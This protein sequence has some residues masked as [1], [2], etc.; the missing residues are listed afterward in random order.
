MHGSAAVSLVIVQDLW[1]KQLTEWEACSPFTPDFSLRT[2]G[3]PPRLRG[4]T[5]PFLIGNA[6]RIS[7]E[8][9]DICV[10]RARKLRA[11]Q[12]LLVLVLVLVLLMLLLLLLPRV[13]AGSHPW[14]TRWP[15]TADSDPTILRPCGLPVRAR[16]AALLVGRAGG[17]SCQRTGMTRRLQIGKAG[18]TPGCLPSRARLG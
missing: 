14:L 16:P 2:T 1:R 9:F 10:G 3:I 13:W 12:S 7:P 6:M 11:W 5:W 4:R 17:H 15:A 8:I 18:P